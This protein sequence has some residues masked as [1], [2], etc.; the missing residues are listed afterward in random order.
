LSKTKGD[1]YNNTDLPNID[2]NHNTYSAVI[3]EIES[4]ERKRG[5]WAAAR[6]VRQGYFEKA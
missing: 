6:K 3:S 2:V 5:G 4:M 1:K